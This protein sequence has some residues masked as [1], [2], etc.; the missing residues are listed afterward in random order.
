MQKL[1]FNFGPFQYGD[2][3]LVKEFRSPSGQRKKVTT[4]AVTLTLFV[5]LSRAPSMMARP[6]QIGRKYCSRTRFL[7]P[8]EI[9]CFGAD[10]RQL[11]LKMFSKRPYSYM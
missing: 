9:M 3:R 8:K 11:A 10:N 4:H 6:L 7:F 2:N 1:I 5:P